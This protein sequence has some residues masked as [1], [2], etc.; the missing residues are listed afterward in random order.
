M[1]GIATDRTL[2]IL[3]SVTFQT[4]MCVMPDP[5]QVTGLKDQSRKHQN[6][7]EKQEKRAKGMEEELNK[8]NGAG[9]WRE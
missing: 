7:A 8:R 4:I 6:F 2:P 9:G 3:H 5:Q 1:G